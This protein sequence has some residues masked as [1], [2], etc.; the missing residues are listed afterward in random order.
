MWDR[1]RR[2]SKSVNARDIR[3]STISRITTFYTQ[4]AHRRPRRWRKAIANRALWQLPITTF[5]GTGYL[6]LTRLRPQGLSSTPRPLMDPGKNQSLHTHTHTLSLSLSL[7]R[8]RR[9]GRTA[10][11]VAATID[12]RDG[13]CNWAQH[14]DH[15]TI[16]IAK[17]TEQRGKQRTARSAPISALIK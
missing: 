13:G 11:A 10:G 8:R 7:P 17:H 4:P 6:P 1:L 14:T 12:S 16:R 2:Q 9:R 5:Y 15:A 3:F